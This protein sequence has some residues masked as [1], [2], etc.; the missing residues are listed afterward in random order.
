[1]AERAIAFPVI[2]HALRGDVFGVLAVVDQILVG[3]R[4]CGRVGQSKQ[5]HANRQEFHDRAPELSRDDHNPEQAPVLFW[6]VSNREGAM[7]GVAIFALGVLAGGIAVHAAIAQSG[8][9]SPNHG[10]VGLNHVAISVPD[11]DKAVTFYTRTMGFPEAFR[12]TN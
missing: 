4:E 3:L 7:R 11:L 5:G 10:I 8:S 9:L 1:L 2:A 6:S 12:V